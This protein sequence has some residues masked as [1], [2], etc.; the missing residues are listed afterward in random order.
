MLAVVAMLCDAMLPSY[1]VSHEHHTIQ[2]SAEVTT[3]I[4]VAE[5]MHVHCCTM[6]LR[7]MS[8]VACHGAA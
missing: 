7:S 2:H 3:M 1:D 5:T 4:H 8:E 6:R